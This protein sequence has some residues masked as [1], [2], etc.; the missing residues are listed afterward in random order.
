MRFNRLK[1]KALIKEKGRTNEWIAKQCCTKPNYIGCI[2]RGER[3]PSGPLVKLLAQ[4]L[5]VP[6]STLS[7]ESEASKAS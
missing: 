6:V 7:D 1:A 4:A 3:N 2:L 5:E